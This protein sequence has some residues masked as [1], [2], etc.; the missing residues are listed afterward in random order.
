MRRGLSEGWAGHDRR[1]VSCGH[2]F[3][4]T[5][6]WC[7]CAGQLASSGC[8]TQDQKAVLSRITDLVTQD[9]PRVLVACQQQDDTIHSIEVSYS[10]R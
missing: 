4:A 8:R 9:R 3:H 6:L 2:T 7:K 5:C 10:I 1:Y